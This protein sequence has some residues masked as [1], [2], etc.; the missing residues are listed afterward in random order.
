LATTGGLFCSTPSG[1]LRLL[2][3]FR[4]RQPNQHFSSFYVS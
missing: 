4:F 2:D 1:Q 3:F